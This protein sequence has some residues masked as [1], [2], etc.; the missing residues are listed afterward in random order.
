[1]Y[2]V[3]SCSYGSNIKEG[4]T[5][6]VSYEKDDANLAISISYFW[7]SD[8]MQEITKLFRIVIYLTS[9]LRSPINEAENALKKR[10]CIVL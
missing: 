7:W 2:L 3:Q 10:L 4:D 5:Q 6:K 9:C 1:M 8:V